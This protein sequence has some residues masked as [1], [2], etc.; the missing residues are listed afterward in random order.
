[1]TRDTGNDDEM[2]QAVFQN[3][4][5]RTFGGLLCFYRRKI[6]IISVTKSGTTAPDEACLVMSIKLLCVESTVCM[7]QA[8]HCGRIRI[9]N[10]GS[11]L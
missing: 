10:M 1:M 5:S 9:V 7:R 6:L 3:N 4:V 11:L 2:K 8:T